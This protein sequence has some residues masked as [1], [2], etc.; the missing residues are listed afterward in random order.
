MRNRI[1]A[2][3][4]LSADFTNLEKE[5]QILNESFAEY[6]HLDIMDGIFV[7]NITFGMPIIKQIRQ[8]TKKILDTHLM[9]VQPERYIEIFKEVGADILTVHYEASIHLDRTINEIKKQGMKAGV[10]INPHTNVNLLDDIIPYADL[11]LIMSVNPGFGGQQFIPNSLKKISILK[12]LILKNNSKT[13]IEVDGGVNLDNY[14]EL[15]EAG[16]DILVSG[17]T[18]FNSDNPKKIIE[19]MMK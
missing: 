19:F 4:L 17:N 1:I 16:A 3:S 15:I 13:L 6:I 9:I 5:L 10:A 11:I 12:E 8:K 2:P 7:P 18:I 14:Q